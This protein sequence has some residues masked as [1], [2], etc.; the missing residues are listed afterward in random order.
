MRRLVLLALVLAGLVFPAGLGLAVYIAAGSS[1][2]APVATARVPTGTIGRPSTPP[3]V[4]TVEEAAKGR[5]GR[6]DEV[7][8]R[9]DPD[10]ADDLTTTGSTAE[11]AI[12]VETSTDGTTTW[13]DR[14]SG[15]SRSGDSGSDRSGRS[16]SGSGSGS[17]RSGSDDD[18]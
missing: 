2:V 7:E 1:L 9:S 11:T 8:H 5:S 14:D 13:D 18:D 4:T 16:G 6:C 3:S 10:C 15:R 17:G 12:T